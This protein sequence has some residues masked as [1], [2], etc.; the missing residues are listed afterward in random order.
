MLQ[1]V[2][3]IVRTT[4]MGGVMFLVPFAIVLLVL[5]KGFQIAVRTVLPLA[6]RLPAQAGRRFRETLKRQT[7]R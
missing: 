7:A 5:G 4:I 3:G 6:K 1:N 2:A